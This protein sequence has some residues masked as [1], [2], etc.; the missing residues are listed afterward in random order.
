MRGQS[1]GDVIRDRRHY[2]YKLMRFHFSFFYVVTEKMS[3]I[4]A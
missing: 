3:F 4:P 1:L 2:M